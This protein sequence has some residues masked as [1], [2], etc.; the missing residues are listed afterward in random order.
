MDFQ[1]IARR[2]FPVKL[3][4]GLSPEKHPRAGM[5]ALRWPALRLLTKNSSMY[6][7]K[8]AC[9]PPQ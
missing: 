4:Q 7:Q 2:I 3:R 9:G 6:A 8:A 5:P 1:D